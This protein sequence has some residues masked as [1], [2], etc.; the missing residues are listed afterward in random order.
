MARSRLS[1]T[2]VVPS[3]IRRESASWFCVFRSSIP[4]PPIPLSTLQVTTHDA[5]YKTEGQDGVAVSFLVGLFH[6]LQH[7]GLTRRC[8]DQRAFLGIQS[9]G[10]G[11]NRVQRRSPV[12]VE[13]V[14]ERSADRNRPTPG[15]SASHQGTKH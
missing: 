7:A 4:G 5:T 1:R 12:A 2:A 8:P 3:S 10:L 15:S 6:S 11:G 14:G 9:E 13:A